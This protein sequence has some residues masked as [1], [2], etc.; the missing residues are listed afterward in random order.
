VHFLLIIAFLDDL[1]NMAL[2]LQWLTRAF[3]QIE[4]HQNDYVRHNS[5]WSYYYYLLSYLS[6]MRIIV[7]RGRDYFLNVLPNIV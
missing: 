2:C 1:G 3:D 6:K 4:R 5:G 7:F